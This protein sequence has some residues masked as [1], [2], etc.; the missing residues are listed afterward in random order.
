MKRLIVTCMVM[1]VLPL[2]MMAQD[3]M[4]FTPTKAQKQAIKA[5]REAYEARTI[6]DTYYSGSDRNVDEY[7]RRGL[8]RGKWTF[9]NDSI[10]NDVIEFHGTKDTSSVAMDYVDRV[11]RGYYDDDD[12][13]YSRRMSR[14]GD[15][16]LS[17]PWLFD[18]WYWGHSPYWYAHWGWYD[19]WFDPFYDPFWGPGWSWGWHAGWGW[20]HWGW[21]DPFWGPGWG[22]HWG[23]VARPVATHNHG[24]S[25]PGT[26]NHGSSFAGTSNHGGRISQNS[27]MSHGGYNPSKDNGAA[28]RA[29]RGFSDARSRG[30]IDSNGHNSAF[31]GAYNSF[32]GGSRGNFGGNS[33]FGGSHSGGSFGGGHSGGFG[34]GHSGGGGFGNSRGGRR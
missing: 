12:Y 19:P 18:R 3:D 7:N 34:G 21:Y 8:Y 27:A 33:S 32:G 14:W 6:D 20:N 15:Y 23:V 9:D 25:F 1:A 2:S 24:G 30:T 29:T 11:E 17:D 4:Y 26:A 16:Y 13:Y 5:Q 22:P 10:G 31:G 28:I